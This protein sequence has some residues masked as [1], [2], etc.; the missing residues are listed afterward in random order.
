M[1]SDFVLVRITCSVKCIIMTD[2][3]QFRAWTGSIKA[4]VI[5]LESSNKIGP[6]SLEN[7]LLTHKHANLS[8]IEVL[9]EWQT[10]EDNLL[11]FRI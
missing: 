5:A 6:K 2:R 1:R 4:V 11:C 9:N 10:Y 7:W 3:L 8:R